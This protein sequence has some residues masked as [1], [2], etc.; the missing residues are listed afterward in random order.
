MFI[1]AF[2]YPYYVTFLQASSSNSPPWEPEVS[3]T[4]NNQTIFYIMQI[5]IFFLKLITCVKL[6]L[7][8][9]DMD[10]HFV[11]FTTD[12]WH[13]IW[14]NFNKIRSIVSK[15]NRVHAYNALLYALYT[16]Y[17]IT[18]WI[19]RRCPGFKI[20][21]KQIDA[22]SHYYVAY[23][24]RPVLNSRYTKFGWNLLRV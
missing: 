3:Q 9:T 20:K 17:I 13:K 23:V 6:T 18:S 15:A 5:N 11:T 8:W 22:L 1:A 7:Y 21:V 4:W 24:F 12:T 19:T 10:Y 16:Y 14:S 2:L